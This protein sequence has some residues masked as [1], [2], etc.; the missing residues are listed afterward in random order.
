MGFIGISQ[1]LLSAANAVICQ[2]QYFIELSCFLGFEGLS[3]NIKIKSSDFLTVWLLDLLVR[4]CD[5]FVRQ[6][7]LP[8]KREAVEV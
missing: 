5:A 8:N 2:V 4:A 7:E 6:A 1:L 3:I